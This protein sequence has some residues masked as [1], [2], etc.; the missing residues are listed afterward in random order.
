MA[1]RF[2]YKTGDRIG[3][4]SILM[5]ERTFKDNNKQ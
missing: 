3:P 5:L 2:K 4:Y 1:G